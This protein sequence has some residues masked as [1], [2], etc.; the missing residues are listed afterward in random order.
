M[1]I[2]SGYY[3]YDLVVTGITIFAL[4]VEAYLIY[5]IIYVSPKTMSAYRPFLLNIAF[6]DT[7]LSFNIGMF[8]PNM[9]Y[10]A[11]CILSNGPYKYLG[12]QFCL[13]LFTFI[14]CCA[15]NG[16]TAQDYCM[17]Y[18]LTIILPNQRIHE[19]FMK[20]QAVV[21]IQLILWAV[22][23]EVSISTLLTFMTPQNATAYLN[24]WYD[25]AIYDWFDAKWYLPP[26]NKNSTI[27][28]TDWFSPYLRKQVW[29][30]VIFLATSEL[31]CFAM[32]AT[33]FGILRKNISRYESNLAQLGFEENNRTLPYHIGRFSRKTYSMHLQLTALI[34]AQYLSPI[35]F[36]AGPIFVI[37][38]KNVFYA[39]S[40][41]PSHA[42]GD[43]LV[44]SFSLYGCANAFLTLAFVAPYRTYTKRKLLD[45]LTRLGLRKTPSTSKLVTP[46]NTNS[47][48][49]LPE[50]SFNIDGLANINERN[51]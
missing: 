3:A 2:G 45:F 22:S 18:R 32:A 1:E 10:P 6:W 42:L 40:D 12:P 50:S 14:V 11:S 15:V 27:I 37:L 46:G 33:I 4:V 20:W 23:L 26:Y 28:C 47:L 34:V 43:S 19:Y 48:N 49:R 24:H 25:D 8:M 16:I 29:S 38:Y 30:G 21:L 7:L 44:I 41:V 5:L 35:I 31:C 17:M 51:V 13:I 36:L 9:L 39:T